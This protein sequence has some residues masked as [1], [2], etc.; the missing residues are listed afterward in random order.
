MTKVEVEEQISRTIRELGLSHI[1]HS[2]IGDER[3]RG[4]SGGQRKRV[5][6]AIEL[7]ARPSVLFL[8]E[9]WCGVVWCGVV[10]CG[11]IVFVQGPI[12]PIIKD[13]LS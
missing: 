11:E 7:V 1:Q 4:I 10:W 13:F 2:V 12:Y 6:I 3:T 5:N 8:D 9:V